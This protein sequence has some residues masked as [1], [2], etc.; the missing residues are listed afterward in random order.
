[1]VKFIDYGDCEEVNV[2]GLRSLPHDDLVTLPPQVSH[3]AVA[4]LFLA[5]LLT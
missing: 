3:F 5:S 4:L 2:K 1:M